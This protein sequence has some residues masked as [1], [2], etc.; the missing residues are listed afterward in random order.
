M[1]EEKVDDEREE[2]DEVA[3]GGDGQGRRTTHL[4]NRGVE[5]VPERR[6]DEPR[7]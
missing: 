3:I 6:Y 1:K 5:H 4:N 7:W 2:E